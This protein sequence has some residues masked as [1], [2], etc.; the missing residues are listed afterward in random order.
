MYAR[1]SIY[2]ELYTTPIDMLAI[3]YEYLVILYPKSVSVK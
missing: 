1:V 2:R 3:S